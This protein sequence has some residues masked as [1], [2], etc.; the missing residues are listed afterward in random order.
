MRDGAVPV[1]ILTEAMALGRL[2]V[3]LDGD[4]VPVGYALL[5]LCDGFALLAQMDVHPA[6]GRKGLDKAL[7]ETVLDAVDRMGLPAL[8]LTTFE[9]VPWNAPFYNRLGFRKLCPDTKPAC[10]QTI[11]REERGAGVSNRIAME[12]II[13][14]STRQ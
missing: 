13:S 10:I 14:N 5:R 3:V 4:W 1:E 7:V 6:H 9:N 8:Y 12:R 11:L 2:W